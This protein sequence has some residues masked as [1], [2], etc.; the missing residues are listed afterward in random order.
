MLQLLG[1]AQTPPGCL[2]YVFTRRGHEGKTVRFGGETSDG[3]PPQAHALG[4]A[5]LKINRFVEHRVNSLPDADETFYLENTAAYV[6]GNITTI[7]AFPLN[8]GPEDAIAYVY[9]QDGRT[10]DQRALNS[11]WML[12][13]RCSQVFGTALERDRVRD[14][15]QQMSALN[16]ILMSLLAPRSYATPAELGEAIVWNAHNFLAA[17]VVALYEYDQKKERFTGGIQIAGR[18]KD[19]RAGSG[20]VTRD[21]V[22]WSVLGSDTGRIFRPTSEPTTS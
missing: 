10:P 8:M 18:L 16:R 20:P 17:D 1:P 15:A 9:Y 3:V 13:K 21:D 12:T 14:R 11:A 22:R 2:P 19:P 5:A 6:K 7:V 4:Q